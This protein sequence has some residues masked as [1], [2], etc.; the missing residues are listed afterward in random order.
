MERIPMYPRLAEENKILGL[1]FADFL[2]LILVYLMVFV[3]LKNLFVNLAMVG[4]AY[5]VLVLYKRK[6]PPRY[7]QA[8]IRFLVLPG[9]YSLT[10][11]DQK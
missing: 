2:I 5:I 1:E 7:T 8:L 11:E 3:F 9:K 10:K 4:A 6:K